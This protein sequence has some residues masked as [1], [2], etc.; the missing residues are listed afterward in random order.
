[1]PYIQPKKYYTNDGVSPTDENYGSYQKVFLADIVNNFMLMFYGN[2]SLVNNE[3]RYKVIFHAKQCI[4]NIAY[5]AS[6]TPISLQLTV[7]ENLKFIFPPDYVNFIKLSLYKNNRLVQMTESI[8]VM[9]AT[10][11]QQDANAEIEFYGDDVILV[12]PSEIDGDRLNGHLK[13]MY[14]NQNNPNDLLNG[15]YGWWIGNQWYFEQSYGRRFGLNTE[16]ATNAPT[17]SIDRAAGVINFSSDMINQ[18]CILEY[19]SDGLYN[20]DDSQIYVNKLFESYVYAYIE[21]EIMSSKLG[22]QQY[23]INS[24]QKKKSALLSN[25]KIRISNLKP[26]RLLMNLRGQN[27]ILK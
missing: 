15:E 6:A 2:G 18:S 10:Q 26:A 4:Q 9:S 12:E 21:Y 3:A 19:I 13:T 23:T 22:V 27:K 20:N 8:Q 11:Y 5:D 24:L 17:Y 14:L 16:T 7:G 25:A 1:M